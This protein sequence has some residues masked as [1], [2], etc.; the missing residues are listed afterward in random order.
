MNDWVQGGLL[1]A[2][3][4]MLLE[5]RINMGSRLALVERDLEWVR[6][7]LVKW[8]MIPPSDHRES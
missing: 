8:G 2:I 4:L 3:L 1:I 7:S 5:A 6:A